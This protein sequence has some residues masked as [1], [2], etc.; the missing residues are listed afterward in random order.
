MGKW[1]KRKVHASKLILN[2]HELETERTGLTGFRKT[3]SKI[4]EKYLI[5]YCDEVIVVSNSIE[6]W[7]KET[8]PKA[9]ITCI[10]N[11]PRL[12]KPLFTDCFRKTFNIPADEI[13]FLYQGGFIQG[14][15]I[16]LLLDTFKNLPEKYHLVFMGYGPLEKEIKDSCNN[17]K[18]IHFHEAVP[19]VELKNY[20]PSA[21]YGFSVIQDCSINYS[22]CM[23]NKLFEYTMYEVPVIVSN[24]VDQSNFVRNNKIGYVLETYTSNALQELIKSLDDKTRME[25]K[26]NMKT[27]KKS[28]SW[29]NQEQK[30]IELYR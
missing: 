8:Y 29:E 30:L 13:V 24:T 7:Y 10:Y 25:L 12:E 4:L 16:N 18:N 6:K 28:I 9:N 20:T 1:L 19:Q 21:D 3:V 11:A 14:R 2:A 5:K 26:E 22:F 27:I 17:Y 23:P 15:G